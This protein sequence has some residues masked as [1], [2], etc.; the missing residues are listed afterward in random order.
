MQRLRFFHSFATIADGSDPLSLRLN[1]Y[2]ISHPKEAAYSPSWPDK[3][4]LIIIYGWLT[5]SR[6]AFDIWHC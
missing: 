2:D 1:S 3:R 4:I 6:H 5:T